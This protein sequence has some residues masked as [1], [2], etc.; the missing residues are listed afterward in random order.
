MPYEIE[1]KDDYFEVRLEGTFTALEVLEAINTL[2]KK[3]PLKKTPD[4][5]VVPE[6]HFIPANWHPIIVK[7]I[8]KLC[9]RDILGARSAVLATNQ[10][11]K[12]LADIYCSE[13]ESLPYST[14]AFTSRREAERWLRNEA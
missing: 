14:R 12:A 10:F 7:A 13:A 11:Y 1:E 4:L 6:G 8:R 9:A 2:K 3:D 5:W